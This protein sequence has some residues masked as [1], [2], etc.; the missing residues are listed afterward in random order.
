MIRKITDIPIHITKEEDNIKSLRNALNSLIRKTKNYE[1]II[2]KADKGS[3]VTIMDKESYWEM[4]DR[5][6]SNKKFYSNLETNDPSDR[7][8]NEVNKFTDKHKEKFTAKE[9][10]Y[11]KKFKYNMANLYVTKVT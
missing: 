11:L 2:K 7:V 3:I 1:I 9:Y 6:L 8:K 5:Q 10:D 4:C